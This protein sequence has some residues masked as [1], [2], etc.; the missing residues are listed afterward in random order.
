MILGRKDGWRIRDLLGDGRLHRGVRDGLRRGL[1]EGVGRSR[2]RH[3]RDE[4]D[5]PGGHHPLD[6]FRRRV[7]GPEHT[8][9]NHRID[10]RGNRNAAGAIRGRRERQH[11][12]GLE[13][14]RKRDQG[15]GRM[16]RPKARLGGPRG[17][18]R[19][20]RKCS[21]TAGDDAKFAFASRNPKS[22]C[23]HHGAPLACVNRPTR[24]VT[25]T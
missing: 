11:R 22:R 8:P 20:P 17:H 19:P 3:R 16:G 2:V 18:G 4:H 25:R 13:G 21:G 23:A 9:C 24:K 7:S 14:G 5:G 10:R 12:V 6:H 1:D 15:G